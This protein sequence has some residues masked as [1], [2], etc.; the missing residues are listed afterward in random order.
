MILSIQEETATQCA[1]SQSQ[2][3]ILHGAK[4]ILFS[5]IPTLE[6]KMQPQECPTYSK[7]S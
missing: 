4:G 7:H 1:S 2:Q 6:G 3:K 5:L